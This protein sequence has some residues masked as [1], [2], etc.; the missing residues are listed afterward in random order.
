MLYLRE[1]LQP[2][3]LE[4]DAQPVQV[5][6]TDSIQVPAPDGSFQRGVVALTYTAQADMLPPASFSS[7]L[8]TFPGRQPMT[9]E[10]AART[11]CRDVARQLGF[12]AFPT[13]DIRWTIPGNARK[14]TVVW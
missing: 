6:L 10:A 7:Y 11:I 12:D 2:E 9:P 13:V 5:T 4:G 8:G 14:R 1:I 3:E